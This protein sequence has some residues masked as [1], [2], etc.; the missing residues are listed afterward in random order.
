MTSNIVFAMTKIRLDF[1]DFWAQFS[2]TENYF[3]KTLRLRFEVEICDHPDVIIYSGS[4]Y[5][6]RLHTCPRV[7]Y[8]GE[9]GMPDWRECDYAL[10]FN[11]LD[12]PRHLRLPLYVLYATPVD[13]I[14]HTIPFT[15]PFP[16]PMESPE[17]VRARKTKFCAFV[18]GNIGRK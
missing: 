8:T 10:T 2:K 6:H 9:A 17:E 12:D 7:F 13:L 15:R 16:E 1:C 5:Q 3:T 18:V 14:H 11:Y 4:G